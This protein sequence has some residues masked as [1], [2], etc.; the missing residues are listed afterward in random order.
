MAGSMGQHCLCCHSCDEERALEEVSTG[1]AHL[2]I[3][4]GDV[5]TGLTSKILAEAKF[6]TVVGPG[7]PLYSTAKAKKSVSI[8]EALKSLELERTIEIASQSV[9][10]SH[11]PYAMVQENSQPYD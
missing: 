5:P 1:E 10:L 9:L 2:A 11:M 6:L 7:H 8:E 3:V 4:T